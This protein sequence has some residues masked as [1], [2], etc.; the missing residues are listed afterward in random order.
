M[1]S[2]QIHA[3]SNKMIIFPEGGVGVGHR[4]GRFNSVCT[5]VCGHT[6]E[7]LTHPQNKVGLSVNKNRSILR[8]CAIKNEPKLT[9]LQQVYLISRKLLIPRYND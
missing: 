9:K 8:L 7:K 1:V 3:Q 6:T 4:M 5:R 2:T